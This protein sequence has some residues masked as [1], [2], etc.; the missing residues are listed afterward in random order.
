MPIAAPGELTPDV[1]IRIT[2]GINP[3]AGDND[4]RVGISDGV[5][6][7][8]F[9]LVEHGVQIGSNRH[10][11]CEIYQG[12]HNGRSAPLGNPVAGGYVLLF[13]PLHRF[14]SCSS[15]NGFATDGKF[16]NQ[17][18][19]NQGLSMILHRYSPNEQYTFHYFLVEFLN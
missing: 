3:P 18:D 1:M 11:P 4:P 5:N 7:N 8:Q 13:D 10:N 19:A 16:L 2:V 9:W 14:G 6:R 15:N 12:T 17:V